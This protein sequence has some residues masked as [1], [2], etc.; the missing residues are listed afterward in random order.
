MAADQ[1]AAGVAAVLGD[2]LV[3][4][5]KGFG[6]ISARKLLL[7]GAGRAEPGRGAGTG[8]EGVWGERGEEE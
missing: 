2:A 8:C 7:R 5:A 6:D 4:P 1:N 3:H